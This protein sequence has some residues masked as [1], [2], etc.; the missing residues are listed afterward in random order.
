VDLK[1][2]GDLGV[3]LGQ[4][5]LELGAAVTPVQTRDHGAVGDVETGKQAGG[6]VPR[7]IPTSA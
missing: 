4:E 7:V 2:V 1:I 6:A 5:L 3:D